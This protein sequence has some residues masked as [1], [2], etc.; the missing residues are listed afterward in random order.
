MKIIRFIFLAD[1]KSLNGIKGQRELMFVN[2]LIF[3]KKT[4]LDINQA[5]FYVKI[6]FL[7]RFFTLQNIHR[8]LHIE[9]N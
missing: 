5:E 1:K 7:L 6:V 3:L 8:L 9:F 2:A 4:L